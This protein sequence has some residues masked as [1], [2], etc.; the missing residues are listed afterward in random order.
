MKAHLLKLPEVMTYPNV[1]AF[2]DSRKA[3]R[4]TGYCQIS[5]LYSLNSAY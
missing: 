4:L 5:A 3:L 1:K 2:L